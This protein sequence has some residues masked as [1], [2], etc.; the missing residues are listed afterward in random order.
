MQKFLTKSLT[1]VALASAVAI[2]LIASSAYGG[3]AIRTN[4]QSIDSSDTTILAVVANTRTFTQKSRKCLYGNNRDLLV[5]MFVASCMKAGT[6]AKIHPDI[7]RVGLSF[8][9]QFARGTYRSSG[10]NAHLNG[11]DRAKRAYAIL[12]N[13]VN[14]RNPSTWAK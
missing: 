14:L 5:T 13:K 1:S 9:E 2:P 10:G 3:T 6:L 7:H 11:T 12:T 4:L 8:L